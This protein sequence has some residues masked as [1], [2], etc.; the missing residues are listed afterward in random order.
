ML[1]AKTLLI[2]QPHNHKPEGRRPLQPKNIIPSES[3]IK[4]TKPGKE[5]H[6]RISFFTPSNKENNPGLTLPIDASLAEE[7]NAVR[8]RLERLRLDRERTQK[9]LQN[10]TRVLDLQMVEME[11]RGEFQKE[12]EIEVDRLYRLKQLQLA[13]MVITL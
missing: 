11:Q 12:L 8:Q 1:A 5:N 7:L 13:C 4:L 9:M 2:R 6:A 3:N 10:R